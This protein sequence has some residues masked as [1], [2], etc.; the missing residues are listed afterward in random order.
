MKK[1]LLILWTVIIGGIIF[2]GYSLLSPKVADTPNAPIKISRLNTANTG[3]KTST[4]EEKKSYSEYVTLG[5]KYF[6]EENYKLAAQNYKEANLINSSFE[7]ILKLGESYL[8]DNQFEKAKAAFMAALK[9]QPGNVTATLGEVRSF[10]GLRDIENAKTILWTLDPANPEI[11]YYRGVL[12]ILYK[13]FED[14]RKL[15]AEIVAQKEPLPDQKIID[16]SQKF[17]DKY[18]IF[19]TYAEGQQLFLQTMMAKALTEV[20]ENSAAIPLLY[21]VIE[22][23]NGYRDAWLILGY[24]YLK[25]GQNT[26][27]IDALSR[28]KDMDPDKA[29]T[30]FF[31][32]LAYYANNDTES[33]IQYIKQAEEKGYQDKT[34]INLKLGELYLLA[35]KFK[36]AEKRFENVA[37]LNPTD[38]N[39]FVKIVWLNVDKLNDPEKAVQYADQAVKLFPE[40]AMSYNLSGWA[41]TAAGQYDQAR[42]YLSKALNINKNFDAANLNLGWLYEKQGLKTLAQEYYKKA[43]TLGDGNSVSTLAAERFN[44]LTDSNANNYKVDISSP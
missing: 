37:A 42:T 3:D 33:A 12:L 9:E 17:L 11:K 6:G 5:D 30:L 4:I 44:N 32:G 23:E 24:A 8:Q 34:L 2:I 20:G 1:I 40:D 38:I 35:E 27:A 18:A 29:E 15:F 36:T 14:A 16:K 31:L 39:I 13:Q 10:L 28:A 43:Y 21:D 25:T 22:Q 7:N 41:S 26:D 19:G